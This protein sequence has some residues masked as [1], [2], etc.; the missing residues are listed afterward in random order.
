[1]IDIGRNVK[2]RHVGIIPKGRS[3]NKSRSLSLSPSL[4]QSIHPC[5]YICICMHTHYTHIYI[6]IY[7]CT[8]IY[9]YV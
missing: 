5:T 8:Y 4:P 6:Y 3:V 2:L 1:M 9:I 7:V